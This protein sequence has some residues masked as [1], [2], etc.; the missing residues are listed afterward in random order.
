MGGLP[1]VQ[2]SDIFLCGVGILGEIRMDADLGAIEEWIPISC[3]PVLH[4]YCSAP[5]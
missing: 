4:M 3:R 2:N 1:I 5:H